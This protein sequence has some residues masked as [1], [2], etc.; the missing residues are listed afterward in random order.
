LVGVNLD[1]MRAAMVAA[2]D[3]HIADAGFAHFAEGDF[4]GV[5]G[6]D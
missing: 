1:V 4:C 3:Q 5:R 6:Q 2:V